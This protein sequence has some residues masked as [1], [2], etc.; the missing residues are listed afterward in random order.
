MNE[1]KMYHPTVN[2]IYFAFAIGLA[3]TQM[4]PMMLVSSLVGSFLY[5]CMLSGKKALQSLAF[6]VPAMVLT[7]AIN[8]LFNH[9]GVTILEYLPDGNPL[10]LESIIYGLCAA[11]S[12]VSVLCFFSSFSS[13]MTSDKFMYLFGRIIPSL[14][15]VLSMTLRFV[16]LF[17][18]RLGKTAESQKCIGRGLEE[19]GVLTKIKNALRILSITVTWALENAIDTA[20]SMKARGYGTGKRTA[21][22]NYRLEKRDVTALLYILFLGV[23]VIVGT[24]SGSVEFSFFPAIRYAYVTMYSASVFVGYFLLCMTPVIIELKEVRRWKYLR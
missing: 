16:P 9:G 1:F 18:Q 12:L 20:D 15:L 4:H 22:S 19:K 6:L 7:A 5:M 14:S 21:Y 2:L 3:C 23:Y 24:V 10:T 17:A 8:P 13:V 11:V